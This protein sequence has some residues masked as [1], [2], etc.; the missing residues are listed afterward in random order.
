[1]L[2]SSIQKGLSSPQAVQ[3]KQRL[4]SPKVVL[5]RGY[6][7]QK[8]SNG[9]RGYPAQSLFLSVEKGLSSRKAFAVMLRAA[10]SSFHPSLQGAVV[11]L[12]PWASQIF[13]ALVNLTFRGLAACKACSAWLITVAHSVLTNDFFFRNVSSFAKQPWQRVIWW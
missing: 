1:M 6:P 10:G 5:F 2:F 3:W 11:S 8:L 4:S 13:M 7:A 9:K 12:L